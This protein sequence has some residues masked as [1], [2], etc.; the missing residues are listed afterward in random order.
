MINILRRRC[1]YPAPSRF[2]FQTEN[3]WAS[4]EW[5]KGEREQY[6]REVLGQ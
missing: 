2:W 3:G 6:E 5:K 4:R 1:K